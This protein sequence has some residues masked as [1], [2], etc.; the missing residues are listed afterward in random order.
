M[1]KQKTMRKKK[2][3]QIKTSGPSAGKSSANL[4][5]SYMAPDT[6]VNI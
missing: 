3:K 5:L 6:F 4:S 1:T 2:K